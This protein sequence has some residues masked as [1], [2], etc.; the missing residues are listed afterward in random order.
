MGQPPGEG[1]LSQAVGSWV[2]I[3]AKRYGQLAWSSGRSQHTQEPKSSCSFRE[4]TESRTQA[5]VSGTNSLCTGTQQQQQLLNSYMR[6]EGGPGPNSTTTI[7][8]AFLPPSSTY[9]RWVGKTE[10]KEA[11]G[12][13]ETAMVVCRPQSRTPSSFSSS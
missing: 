7:V 3:L 8:P 10:D 6:M 13:A 5:R 11:A 2:L 9:G 4:T 12:K 1:P